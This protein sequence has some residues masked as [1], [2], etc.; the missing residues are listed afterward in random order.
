MPESEFEGAMVAPRLLVVSHYMF[1]N[2]LYELGVSWHVT[3]APDDWAELYLRPRDE[4][5]PTRA[6]R[7]S[8]WSA[9]LAGE[10]VEFTDVAPPDEVV[11]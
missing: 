5:H 1:T 6:F 7:V 10:P 3:V 11:R 2:E 8:S 9:A 4:L